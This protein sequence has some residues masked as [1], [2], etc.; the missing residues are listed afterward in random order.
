[1]KFT[2]IAFFLLAA[3]T[4][5]FAQLLPQKAE[6]D[7]PKLDRAMVFKVDYSDKTEASDSS[8]RKINPSI[9]EQ[10]KGNY[11]KN[12]LIW[13]GLC[14]TG[15]ALSAAFGGHGP[16]WCDPNSPARF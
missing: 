12:S 5:P 15:A 13:T 6:A 16:I 9:K 1:M 8:S 11:L 14:V 2:G 7:T 10:E 3:A 4:M